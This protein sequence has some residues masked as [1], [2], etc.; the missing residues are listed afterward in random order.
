[1]CF[2]K[3]VFAKCVLIRKLFTKTVQSQSNNS[4]SRS[5]HDSIKQTTP[6]FLLP[7]VICNIV[8]PVTSIVCVYP[9]KLKRRCIRTFD[10]P[11]VRL[12]IFCVSKITGWLN[13]FFCKQNA[14]N[15]RSKYYCDLVQFCQNKFRMLGKRLSSFFFFCESHKS[16]FL[17]RSLTRLGRCA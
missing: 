6:T 15:S 3:V 13:M 12:K 4:L 2:L 17:L 9:V 5:S 10:N 1:M 16:K 11:Y 8:Q 14:V 7:G